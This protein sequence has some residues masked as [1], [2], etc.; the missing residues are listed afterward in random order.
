M[1]P[2]GSSS[3][4]FQYFYLSQDKAIMN[5]W[6]KMIFLKVNEP[7]FQLALYRQGTAS[8]QKANIAMQ[9][10]HSLLET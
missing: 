2:K 6:K 7:Q 3:Q 8:I 10:L 1:Y 4:A 9:L 5:S